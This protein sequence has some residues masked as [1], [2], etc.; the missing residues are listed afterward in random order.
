MI[1]DARKHANNDDLSCEFCVVGAG[2]AGIT[3]ALELARAGK[4]VILLEAGGTRGSSPAQRLYEGSLE[5]P[6]LHLPLDSDRHREL[7]GTTAIWGGRCIPLDPID[8]EERDYAPHSGWPVS[9]NELEQ[10]Y[11]R[12]HEWCECGD[13]E[14]DSRNAIP[15]GPQEMIGGFEDGELVTT[16]LERWSPPTHFGKRYRNDMETTETLRVFINAV[17]VRLDAPNGDRVESVEVATFAE[18]RFKVRAET[19]IL[20]GGGLETTRQLLVSGIGDASESG[21]LG[22]GYQCHLHGVIARVRFGENVPVVSGYETDP[23]EVYC[24]RRFWISEA[25]QRAHQILNTYF[26]LDRPLIGDPEHG[27]GL[28]SLT[29]F[30][31]RLTQGK[32]QLTPGK[33]KYAIYWSHFKNVLAG[34]PEVISFLPQ[35]FRKRFLQGRRIPSMLTNTKANVYHLYYHAEQAANRSCRVTISDDEKDELGVP[36]LHLDYRITDLDVESVLRAHELV[37][38]ELQRC[39]VGKLEYED[40]PETVIREHQAVLGHHIGTTRMS[41]EPADGVVDPDCRVHGVENLYVASSSVFPTSSQANPTLAIV[42]LALRLA[43]HLRR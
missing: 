32:R 7:G 19:T 14:Y 22:R 1:A 31:K 18:T 34:S 27:S 42:A 23:D 38:R 13:V 28:L 35:F 20:A 5:N 3:I 8:H 16:T 39:E 4:D 43:D 17:A 2:A 29:F 24:R 26:L 40:D 41:V 37:D 25:A 33:G 11:E 30:A 6:D 21:W 10:F 15:D 12:A 36:R 9:A